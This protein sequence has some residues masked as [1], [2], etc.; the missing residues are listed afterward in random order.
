MDRESFEAL[1]EKGDML[2]YTEYNGNLYGTPRQ[3]IEKIAA[4]GKN[5]LLILDLNGIK[6]LKTKELGVKVVSVYIYED[7][8]VIEQRL[9]DRYLKDKPTAEK[10]SSFVKRKNQNISDYVNL[11]QYAEYFDFF[12]KNEELDK[13]VSELKELI[14]SSE[15]QELSP[16]ERQKVVDTLYNMAL[17][18]A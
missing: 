4:S 17:K 3:Q 9:Y 8:N 16:T 12:L 1:I 13:A 2:E 7:I 15:A 5:P 10:L 11:A 6:S 14:A 18:K